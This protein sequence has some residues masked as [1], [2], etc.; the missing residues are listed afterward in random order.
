MLYSRHCIADNEKQND[1]L[2]KACSKGGNANDPWSGSLD[3]EK[4]ETI[5]ACLRQN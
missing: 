5:G 4:Q 3:S 1:K 2:G